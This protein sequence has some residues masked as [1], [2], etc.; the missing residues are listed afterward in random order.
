MVCVGGVLIFGVGAAFYLRSTLLHL[1]RHNP[2]TL[3]SSDQY[4]GPE[5]RRGPEARLRMACNKVKVF[6]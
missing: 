5:P 6:W 3:A 2:P 1:D 4:P